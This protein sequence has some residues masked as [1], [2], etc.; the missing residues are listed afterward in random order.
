MDV[1]KAACEMA[2]Q[3]FGEVLRA[4]RSLDARKTELEAAIVLV[5]KEHMNFYVSETEAM[6][7]TDEEIRGRRGLPAGI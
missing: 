4:E 1:G 2:I 6:R 7:A 3:K 5:P